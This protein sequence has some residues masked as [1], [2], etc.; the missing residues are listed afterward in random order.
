MNR[1]IFDA[2]WGGWDEE[3]HR[4]HT[5]ACWDA[6]DI[7]IILCGRQQVGMIQVHRH[8]DALEISEVQVARTAQGQ[9]I[10]TVLIREVVARAADAGLAV[11]LSVGLQNQRAIALYQRLGF[12]E[13]ERSESH[14]HMVR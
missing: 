2:T 5:D 11:R 9:G 13:V 1:E 14:V 7:E 3:R 12:V 8:V 10:G 4:R 6:G